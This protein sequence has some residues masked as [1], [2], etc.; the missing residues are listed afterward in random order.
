MLA[1]KWIKIKQLYKDWRQSVN[2]VKIFY[3]FTAL[4]YICVFLSLLNV[5][6]LPQPVPPNELSQHKPVAVS[7]EPVSDINLPPQLTA[8]TISSSSGMAG[9]QTSDA[10]QPVSDK[11]FD[12]RTLTAEK[13]LTAA[14][15]PLPA[16]ENT[17][18]AASPPSQLRSSKRSTQRASKSS[19]K[20]SSVSDTVCDVVLIA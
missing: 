11:V 17:Q 12:N 14:E 13:P 10:A 6:P 1:S 8:D 2:K 4:I 9:Q 19:H 18:L 16:V 5:Q 20:S 7:L 15:K 3:S